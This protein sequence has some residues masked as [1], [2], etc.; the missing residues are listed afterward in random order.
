MLS[1]SCNLCLLNSSQWH[2]NYAKIYSDPK[3][4]R[5]KDNA[6]KIENCAFVCHK[7]LCLLRVDKRTNIHNNSTKQ[8]KHIAMYSNHHFLGMS[9]HGNLCVNSI[10]ISVYD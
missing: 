8:Y 5:C 4:P 10:T 3:K 1:L 6:Y 2:I 7:E 9:V